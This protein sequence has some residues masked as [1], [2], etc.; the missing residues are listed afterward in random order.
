MNIIC[1][2]IASIF[3]IFVMMAEITACGKT[4]VPELIK[5]LSVSKIYINPGQGSINDKIVSDGYIIPETVE[6]MAMSS[7]KSY[8][9]NYKLGDVVKKGDLIF[10][11]NEK[12]DEE[13]KLAK[14]NLDIKKQ[15]NDYY[16]STNKKKLAEM[17][18]KL[19]SLSGNDYSSYKYDIEQ[20]V[21]KYEYEEKINEL[22]YK[23]LEETYNELVNQKE[24]LNYYSPID[25]VIS[26]T[27][28]PVEN[29]DIQ[30]NTV[31]IKITDES[32]KYVTSKFISE[33]ILNEKSKVLIQING[34]NYDDYELVHYSADELSE[35]ETYGLE[36]NTRFLIHNLSEDVDFGDYAAITIEYNKTDDCIYLPKEA[37]KT[38]RESNVKYVVA[39]DEKGDEI[40]KEITTGNHTEYY[41][42]ITS[43]LTVH[44]KVYLCDNEITYG[45][46]LSESKAE[47]G[48]Y[49]ITNRYYGAYKSSDINH[50]ISFDFNFKL[51]KLVIPMNNEIEIK[52]GDVICQVIPI[53][54][55]SETEQ[56]KIDY[57]KAYK[58][59]TSGKADYKKRMDNALKLSL[60]GADTEEKL[61][62]R[63]EYNKLLSGYED[64]CKSV[65]KQLEKARINYELIEYAKNEKPYD[66]KSKYDGLFKY[67][68]SSDNIILEGK[69]YDANSKLGVISDIKYYNLYV[70]DTID[71]KSCNI[72]YK[73]QVE[74]ISGDNKFNGTA[75]TVNSNPDDKDE[76][77]IKLSSAEDY[78]LIDNENTS[79]IDEEISVNDVVLIN[80]DYVYTDDYGKYYV[81]IKTD[82]MAYKRYVT[83]GGK[84]RLDVEKVW[85]KSGLEAGEICVCF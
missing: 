2:K 76:V 72:R 20:A 82:D 42:E 63:Y 27:A 7:G 38:N 11:V 9:V 71:E 19:N 23:K 47:T 52:A 29:S 50:N 70:K 6:V 22:E 75:I 59:S 61:N 60:S 84:M 34:K 78:I 55:E 74:I 58:E 26:Y 10:S 21:I 15:L 24:Y 1:K 68:Y 46:K 4:K 57:D 81:Y 32:K 14:S 54:S 43:G 17:N 79:V 13:V 49:S 33:E 51:H 8:N 45:S 44:D 67:N 30:K 40:L 56:I 41:Y 64:Y 5:P 69:E 18:V 37:I 85:I 62:A 48:D 39:L 80:S 35:I 77:V 25:G 36:K 83:I 3:L 73:S 12:Y 65:D 31:A 53:L 66:I 28:S 16:K